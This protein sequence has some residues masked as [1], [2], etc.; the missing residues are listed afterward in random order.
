MVALLEALLRLP[1]L[2][3]AVK[4]VALTAAMKLTARLTSQVSSRAGGLPCQRGAGC[5][6]TRSSCN[7]TQHPLQL[8]R[9]C[10]SSALQAQQHLMDSKQSGCYKS[11]R[12][13][14]FSANGILFDV[15][16]SLHA[17]CAQ[18]AIMTAL[19]W[20]PLVAPRCPA[21]LPWLSA[22]RAASCWRCRR[23]AA[24][25][26]GCWA[27][28]QPSRRSC[29]SACRHW[30]RRS[31]HAT[32]AAGR[33]HHHPCLQVEQHQGRQRM[34]QRQRQQEQALHQPLRLPVTTLLTCWAAWMWQ[35][36]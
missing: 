17:P 23:A 21:C 26:A 25:T 33:W 4:E 7:S 13:T 6:A 2:D 30:T 15:H 19:A 32:W 22:T 5:Q 36:R 16:A 8:M 35:Q 27:A 28:T 29:W 24:S 11:S 12:S 1:K 34:G 20:L 14:C 18:S 31:T 3:P 10:S 9:Y